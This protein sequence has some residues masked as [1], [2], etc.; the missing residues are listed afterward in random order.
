K[1]LIERCIPILKKTYISTIRLQMLDR[2]KKYF[3]G[4]LAFIDSIKQQISRL[5]IIIEKRY[6]IL[7]KRKDMLSRIRLWL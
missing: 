5:Q 6:S 1:I 3:S 7:A 4:F 2:I